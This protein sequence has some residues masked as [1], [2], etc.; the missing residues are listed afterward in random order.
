MGETVSPERMKI[1]AGDLADL[2]R[3]QLEVAF[4][5]ARRE[6]KF[7]PRISELRDLAGVAAKD[8]RNVETEAA[9]KFVND[10]LRKWGV[11]LMPIYSG[12]KRIEAPA[13][14]PRI[15]Y[16][17]RRIGGLCGL[18]QVTEEKR[19]FMF[20]DFC[21][22]Y[23][24]APIAD[25]LA[26]QLADKFPVREGQVK[27]LTDGASIERPDVKPVPVRTFQAKPVPQPLTDDQLRARRE[28]LARQAQ[29]LRQ[30]H[31]SERSDTQALEADSQRRSQ[32]QARG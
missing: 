2:D 11:D 20:R 15:A 23:N 21:E 29:L 10:Y 8:V 13:L 24:V 6:L 7:F 5:R 26:P 9:W 19:P 32:A 18:N 16:A 1:Y 30:A 14:P 25:L 12:G 27:Q 31:H 22:A 3:S 17:L 28:M 4:T